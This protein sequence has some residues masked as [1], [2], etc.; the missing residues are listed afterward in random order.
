MIEKMNLTPV[1]Q[2]ETF[3]GTDFDESGVGQSEAVLAGSDKV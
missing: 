1:D 2:N 3:R